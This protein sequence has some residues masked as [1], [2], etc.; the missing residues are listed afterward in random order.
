[1]ATS[2]AASRFAATAT[3]ML[4]GFLIWAAHFAAI[5]GLTGL[6]CA[7]GFAETRWFAIPLVLLVVGLLTVVAV[8]VTAMLIVRASRDAR[9]STVRIDATACFIEW[10]TASAG[11]LAI[12]AMIWDAL[13]V[14]MVPV[15]G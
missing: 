6:A 11:G 5:Y 8:A 3:R 2:A 14:L 10:M 12:V 7:R 4:G 1:M 15:C 13:P 9:L